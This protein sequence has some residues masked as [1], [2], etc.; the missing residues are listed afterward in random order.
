M[1]RDNDDVV[2]SLNTRSAVD[3]CCL[4]DALWG[5]QCRCQLLQIRLLEALEKSEPTNTYLKVYWFPVIEA[6][7]AMA[8]QQF[9]QAII[10]LEPSLPYELGNLPPSGTSSPI[11]PA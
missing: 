4:S 2:S 5:N 3:G 8:Q 11:Y 6:S 1:K 10:A 7:I 9:D